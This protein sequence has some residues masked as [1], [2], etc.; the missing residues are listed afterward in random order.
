MYFTFCITT[1]IVFT[2]RGPILC[3]SKVLLLYYLQK[4]YHTILISAARKNKKQGLEIEES[5]MEATVNVS[6]EK[7]ASVAVYR[8]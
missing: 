4:K 2:I 6:E 5:E 8:K 3:C 7:P 1:L